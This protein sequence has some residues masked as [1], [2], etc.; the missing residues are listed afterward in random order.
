[1][2]LD[3][4]ERVFA[5]GAV[6]R[7]GGGAGETAG[8][9][10]GVDAAGA[11]GVLD[12]LP[13]EGAAT[14]GGAGRD[15]ADAAAA[16]AGTVVG[17]IDAASEALGRLAGDVRCG[18]AVRGGV[19][20]ASLVSDPEV[21]RLLVSGAPF[22]RSWSREATLP[23]V[24]TA[25]PGFSTLGDVAGASGGVA[26]SR[27]ALATSGVVESSEDGDID[28]RAMNSSAVASR[29]NSTANATS[30]SAATDASAAAIFFGPE[31]PSAGVAPN[32]ISGSGSGSRH[33]A[34]P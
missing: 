14:G 34:S 11:V 4:S 24:A 9:E 29:I 16:G 26:A 5:A 18:G 10:F 27:S 2:K 22:D 1:M 28:F 32:E 23:A 15:A 20:A 12:E 6:S 33:A 19:A 3:G 13:R 21:P 30:A 8:L 17:R 25:T 7:A 31:R